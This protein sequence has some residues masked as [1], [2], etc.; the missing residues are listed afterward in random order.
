MR[1]T[2]LGMNKLYFKIQETPLE[3]LIVPLIYNKGLFE[4][5]YTTPNYNL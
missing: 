1:I 2:F 3:H 4:R 5:F